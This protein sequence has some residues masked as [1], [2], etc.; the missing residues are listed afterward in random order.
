[1]YKN[2]SYNVNQFDWKKEENTF[3]GDALKLWPTNDVY[4]HS[5]PNGRKAFFIA[6]PKTNNFRRFIF[7]KESKY[8]EFSSED[9]ILCKIINYGE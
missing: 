1:M 2:Y 4:Y 9:G 6:N 5:F 8:L 7:K 3:Y